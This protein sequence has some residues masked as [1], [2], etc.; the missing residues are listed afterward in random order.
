MWGQLA[1]QNA[2]HLVG[3]LLLRNRARALAL[4]LLQRLRGRLVLLLQRLLLVAVG[5][6]L[7]QECISRVGV[8]PELP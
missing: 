8:L 3:D 6:H 2:P 7:Q 5:V 4:L 1:S